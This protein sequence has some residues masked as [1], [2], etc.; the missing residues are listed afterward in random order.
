[1]DKINFYLLIA[2]LSGLVAMTI[3]DGHKELRSTSGS[4]G[5]YLLSVSLL[6]IVGSFVAFDI[7][8]ICYPDFLIFGAV[9]ALI[10]N[11]S[12][13]LVVKIKEIFEGYGGD[14]NDRK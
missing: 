1:M 14:R 2:S 5:G 12:N 10:G 4:L 13:S 6:F 9:S 3:K 11:T 7:F 8:G